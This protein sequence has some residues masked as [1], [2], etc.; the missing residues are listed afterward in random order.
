MT[1]PCPSRGDAAIGGINI[2]PDPSSAPLPAPRFL[3]QQGPV[4]LYALPARQSVGTLQR[5]ASSARAA[6]LTAE[7]DVA[8]W[9]KPS[10][11]VEWVVFLTV[12]AKHTTHARA[13]AWARVCGR[14]T[15]ADSGLL[16]LVGHA[17][18]RTD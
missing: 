4:E 2:S 14:V 15:T 17:G 18:Q 10:V 5:N 6:M 13:F 3:G 8:L 1:D 7:I 16:V 12:G 9:V 11:L